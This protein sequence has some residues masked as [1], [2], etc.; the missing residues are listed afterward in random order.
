LRLVEALASLYLAVLVI[1]SSAIIL[2]WATYVEREHGTAAVR[3]A[4]YGTWWFAALLGLLGVN[5]FCAAVVRFPWKR[6]QTGFV[7]THAGILV[8]LAGC[9]LSRQGGIDAQM[10]V[11]ERTTGRVAFEDTQHME[12]MI[13]PSGVGR[14][15][16]S[17][18]ARPAESETEAEAEALDIPLASGP[19]NWEDFRRLSWFPWHW[20][21]RD[22]GVIYE[23]DGVRLEVLDYLSDST[24]E[25]G[26]PLKLQFKNVEPGK[27]WTAVEL[28][29]QDAANPQSPR[30]RMSLGGR[31]ELP[32][33]QQVVFWVARS[34]AETDA[35]L[36]SRPEGPLGPQGQ[37]VLHAA[38]RKFTFPVAELEPKTRRPLG[39]TGL[40]LE[41][42]AA[43]P[44][45]AQ[46]DFQ[47]LDLRVHARA[48]PSK[49]ML[50]L[51]DSPEFSQQDD[52][53][54]VYGVYWAAP[55]P[56]E[57]GKDA[58]ADRGGAPRIDILQGADGKLLYRAWRSPQVEA[59]AAAP[60]GGREV[61][62]FAGTPQAVLWRL[63]EFRPHDRP[64][65]MVRP[66][67]FARKKNP[68]HLNRSVRLR[69]TVDGRSEEFWLDGLPKTQFPD[70]PNE[71]QRRVVAGDG[72]RVAAALKWDEV[73]V[74]FDVYLHK[75]DRR[76]DPGT[77]MAS[78]YSSLV[79]IR[80][81]GKQDK[82]IE[83]KVSITLNEPK[84]FRDP[85]SGRSYRLF[86]ESF[87]GPWKPGDAI[88][89]ELVG[90]DA[91]RD[92]LFIS[93]LTVNYDP[94]R[95]LKYTG[96]LLVVAGVAIMFYM[97]AYF[98]RPRGRKP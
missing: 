25:V 47:L 91:S 56:A 60:A 40:E 33:G 39:D 61:A 23:R 37:L 89:D 24:P 58:K 90:A 7:V 13:Y 10:P 19:F 46:A 51:A 81:R 34:Q 71:D 66:V 77:S 76:L 94:G 28:A 11:F 78:H 64:G 14:S 3:F 68:A 49:R 22:R 8:L 26:G 9:W 21:R 45:F 31:H 41:R 42:A 73:D 17:A 57:G 29:M 54:G 65:A 88:F 18:G 1:S 15:G 95:G 48:G 6:H 62:S 83:E 67:E 82:P 93:F 96:S 2:A 72:R 38:G 12:L 75:F 53:H 55:R 84:D 50:L 16:E 32:G 4:V 92:Q 87:S 85:S 70:P 59:I 30:R 35:F 79:D 43:N 97:R 44:R 69:L 74:G 86:Q 52:E 98:F 5:V 80:E 27:E 20:A 36:D 63:D